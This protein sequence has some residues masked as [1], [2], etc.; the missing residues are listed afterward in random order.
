MAKPPTIYAKR[1]HRFLFC[2]V[3]TAAGKPLHQCTRIS[4]HRPDE[5]RWWADA[6][7]AD[8]RRRAEAGHLLPQS[9]DTPTPNPQLPLNA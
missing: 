5:A 4:Q 7:Q 2:V 3:R 6:K 1:G 9:P 8:I